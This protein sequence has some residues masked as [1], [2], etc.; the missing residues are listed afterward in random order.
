LGKKIYQDFQLF[1]SLDWAMME[2]RD[3]RFSII[4]QITTKPL[5]SFRLPNFFIRGGHVSE[6]VFFVVAV[7]SN[8]EKAFFEKKKIFV[9]ALK[10]H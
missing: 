2:L 7:R 8:L 6:L 5:Q 4:V 3:Y 9:Y 10:R 1:P